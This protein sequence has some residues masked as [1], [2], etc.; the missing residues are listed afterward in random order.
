MRFCSDVTMRSGHSLTGSA[1][2]PAVSVSMV[3]LSE[4]VSPRSK[5]Q[6]HLPAMEGGK[7]AENM[8]TEKSII[9]I[10]LKGEYNMPMLVML[11]PQ[12]ENAIEI[13]DLCMHH[14]PRMSCPSFKVFVK[15]LIADE[16]LR[17]TAIKHQLLPLYTAKPTPSLS[18]QLQ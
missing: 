1:Y 10:G 18:K 6:H 5:H 9:S 16:E 17:D 3:F 12:F 11:S 13:E 2:Y 4:R 7:Q 15:V 8:I 14:Q